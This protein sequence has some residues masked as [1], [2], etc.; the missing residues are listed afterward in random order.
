MKARLTLSQFPTKPR[1]F[2][3]AILALWLLVSSFLAYLLGFF[4]Q[5]A[6]VDLQ[7]A[8]VVGVSAWVVVGVIPT[9]VSWT[10]AALLPPSPELSML[11]F[12]GS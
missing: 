11:E 12:V 10:L 5:L 4:L 9:V 3:G 8:G 7:L 2:I 1:L 6:G